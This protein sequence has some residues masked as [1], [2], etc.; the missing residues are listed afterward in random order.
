MELPSDIPSAVATQGSAF[1]STLG[2]G[3]LTI[4]AG[5]FSGATIAALE[6]EQAL[7]Q[8]SP[9]SFYTETIS[10]L[11]RVRE[12]AEDLFNL[13]DPAF[14]SLFNRV[15]TLSADPT[16]VIT[17]EELEVLKAF[18][19]AI[20]GVR[21]LLSA[22]ALFRSSFDERIADIIER[23]SDNIALVANPAVR[24]M[25]LPANMPLERL[26]QQELGDST[27]WG[28]IAEVN[29]LEPPYIINDPSIEATNVLRPGDVVLIPTPLRNG[30]SA[31]AESIET[32]VT[33]NLNPVE[34]S[35]GTDFMI[36]PDFDLSLT[37]SGD[38]ELVAGPDNMAQAVV[39]KLSYEP[40]E[41]MAFPQL[42]AGIVPG[43]KFPA[44]QDIQDGVTNT[45]LQD[46]RVESIDELSI[47]RDGTALFLTFNLKIKRIDIPVPISIRI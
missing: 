40:G 34:R 4:D 16:K 37:P 2:E 11:R 29:N 9:R 8:Q 26:A 7:A 47:R 28:E 15:A 38:L 25:R 30:F 45:L 10:E 23:F 31:A 35:L 36:T 44:L 20:T 12:N 33:E 18:N 39:L 41:V 19:D 42:G 17:D 5:E 46:T 13:G 22:E 1:L 6:E 27:R 43:Q 32:T 21:L 24:E 14:D 3:L